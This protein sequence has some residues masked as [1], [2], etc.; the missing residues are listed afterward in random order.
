MK[1]LLFILFLLPLFC[2]AQTNIAPQFKR[3][4]PEDHLLGYSIP[5]LAGNHW[6]VDSTWVRQFADARTQIL[7]PN[8]FKGAG[9]GLDPFTFKY[10]YVRQN[11]TDTLYVHN[12]GHYLFMDTLVFSTGGHNLILRSVDMQ[13]G[14]VNNFVQVTPA[15]FFVSKIAD[16][17]FHIF[18]M[19]FNYDTVRVDG[20]AVIFKRLQ[21]GFTPVLAQDAANKAYVDNAVAG[22]GVN[23]YNA[24]GTVTANR[25]LTLSG[26][27]LSIGNSGSDNDYLTMNPS[28]STIGIALAQN[29]TNAQTFLNLN[30]SLGTILGYLDQSSGFV[31]SLRFNPTDGILFTDQENQVGPE[32]T[33]DYSAHWGTHPLALIT[34]Q[35][36]GATYN[37][38]LVSG[39]NIKTVNGNSLLGSGNVVIAAG[40]SSVTASNG[41][42]S[43]G[44]GTPNITFTPL[45]FYSRMMTDGSGLPTTQ[46]E[47]LH[48]PAK[49][50]TAAAL[51]ANTYN[52]G[53]AGVGATLTG[54]SNGA[55]SVDGSTPS[56]ND[57]IL[58]WNEST[59]ANN[60]IY[61]VTQV[62]DGSHPYIL[63]RGTYSSIAAN[64][65]A[66]SQI[67]IQAGSTNAKA[68]FTQ[69]TT[70]TITFG[71][72]ALVYVSN[73]ISFVTGTFSGL[74]TPPSPYGLITDASP[75]SSSTNPV[76]SGG[77]YTAINAIIPS[78]TGN[79]GKFLQTNGTSVLWATAGSGSGSPLFGTAAGTNTYTVT[80]TGVAAYTAGD[81][82]NIKFTNANTSAVVTLNINSL[83]AQ[84]VNRVPGNSLVIGDI[85]AGQTVLLVY[86]GTNFNTVTGPYNSGIRNGGTAQAAGFNLTGN[87]TT[88]GNITVNNPALGVV[89]PNYSP[90]T[91][92]GFGT[93]ITL[94]EDVLVSTNGAYFEWSGNPAVGFAAGGKWIKND[95]GVIWNVPWSVSGSK[96]A[97]TTTQNVQAVTT[98]HAGL[99]N[100]NTYCNVTAGTG[101]I[102]T[103]V[104]YTDE[105]SVSQS[106]TMGSLSSVTHSAFSP[107]TIDSL[108]ASIITVTTTVTGTVTYDTY[109]TI[110]QQ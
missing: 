110:S 68:T 28:V 7:D 102:T 87:S 100:I 107:I 82:Y 62:G 57:R 55:I 95:G 32:V 83:G 45:S 50:A 81:T 44:G 53:T 61:V 6:V 74:G 36:A 106:I 48:Q 38:L 11:L 1:K 90:I 8:F 71:T 35:Y 99:Y 60:G 86:D 5:G 31:Q 97:Q 59:Q 25:T 22:S 18:N 88:T 17:T 108:T 3:N 92:Q 85:L 65:V 16:T 30:S 73:A 70:G 39:T 56:V 91:M 89:L 24:N 101:S 84:T 29:F 2:F 12:N 19:R 72:T 75:T 9:T 94:S 10:H 23:I 43:S 105:H 47:L 76:Q 26:H 98:T 79:S 34:K 67:Y 51:A 49:Y 104:T 69:T 80:I 15:R 27:T 103:T 40:V 52:N 13:L 109:S 93:N 78:Q 21:T 54:N 41:I 77:T 37:P 46:A 64:M 33:A 58:V 42:T 96:L 63:T 14:D 4:I 20:R 66:G